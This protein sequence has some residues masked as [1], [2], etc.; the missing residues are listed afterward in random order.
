[1]TRRLAVL[2]LSL[3]M[4]PEHSYAQDFGGAWDVNAVSQGQALKNS[5]S[6]RDRASNRQSPNTTRAMTNRTAETCANGARMQA[7]GSRDARLVRLARLC[8]QAG[9]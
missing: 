6:R 2:F 4:T 8:R 7:S 1:M 5:L 3:S 9:Y